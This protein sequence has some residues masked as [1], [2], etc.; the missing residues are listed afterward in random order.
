MGMGLIALLGATGYTGRLVAAELARGDRPYRLGARDAR[1]L[2]EVP[3]AAHGGE[4]VV[5]AANPSRL[6]A[7][8]DGVEVLINT[9]GPFTT[10]GMPVVEAAVRNR[11]A[12]VDSTGEPGFMSE[13]YR[14]FADAPVA[15]VPACG[16]DYIPG[17]LAAAIAAHDAG[18]KVDS[19]AVHYE[20]NA[21]LPSRG[22]ARSALEVMG[23]APAELRATRVAFPEGTRRYDQKV[24]K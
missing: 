12:Y 5:D 21:M 22:T 2:A 19:V 11:V 15:I 18:G 14:R 24:C 23:H 9:V 17:D 20:T 10:L 1:R 7:F 6:D 16:F 8:L 4:F 13:V 3:R